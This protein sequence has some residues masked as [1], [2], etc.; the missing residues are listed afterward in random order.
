MSG[1]GIIHL[2]RFGPIRPVGCGGTPQY[3]HFMGRLRREVKT[4]DQTSQA[5]PSDW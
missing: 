2:L 1:N 5:S 3:P 4:T